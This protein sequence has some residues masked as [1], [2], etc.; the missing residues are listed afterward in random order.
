MASCLT[1]HREGKESEENRKGLLDFHLGT[2]STR[3]RFS[4]EQFTFPI[5]PVLHF[6]WWISLEAIW[7]CKEKYRGFTVVPEEPRGMIDLDNQGWLLVLK[8]IRRVKKA[9]RIAEAFLISILER[10]VLGLGSPSSSLRSPSSPG[11]VVN[12]GFLQKLP[13]NEKRST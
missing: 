12:G 10:V 5:Q 6:P 1:I 4:V 2:R 3:V 8:S 7:Q 13:N 9:K 11:S